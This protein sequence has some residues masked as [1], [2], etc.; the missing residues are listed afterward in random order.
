[1]PDLATPRLRLRPVT[2]GEARTLL[3]REPLE[4]L[5]FSPG[6]PMPD[7]ADGLGFLLSHLV[8]DFGFYLVVR[9]EDVLVVGEIGFV[10][11]PQ[12]GAVTIGYG[13]VP[14]ERRRGYATEAIRGL[15]EWALRQPGV[16][17][18][19]AQTLPDNE[20]S[21][22]ALLRA[23]FAEAEPVENVRR[24]ALRVATRG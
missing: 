23:G 2:T 24:F 14:G 13:I 6:Y 15:S 17:E 22:R 9:T 12:D 10:G 7:T 5:R 3:A 19:R 1:V 20:P 16:G 4:S 21:V 18:V 11:P 8:E